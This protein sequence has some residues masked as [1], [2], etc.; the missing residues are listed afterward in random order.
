MEQLAAYDR[1]PW[2]YNT[3]ILGGDVILIENDLLADALNALPQDNRDILLMYWFLEMADREIAERM[4]L[5]RKTINNRRLKSYRL[6]K[7]LMGG[8]TDA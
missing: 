5:A 3:F 6:L 7:E 4:N 8:D 1:Y 2:E